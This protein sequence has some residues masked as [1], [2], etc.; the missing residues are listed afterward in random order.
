M[1]RR[2]FFSFHFERDIW[3]ANQVRN[4]NVVVGPDVAGFFD[5]SEYE[6]AKKKGDEAIK[7]MIDRHLEN[8]TVTVVLIG[9]ET[10]SRPWVQYEIQQSIARKNGLLGVQ[11]HHLKDQT[12]ATD[13]PGSTPSVPF[14]V[15]FPVYQWDGDVSR[16]S[17]EIEGAGV[18]CD[19]LRRGY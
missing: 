8:T 13:Y 9:R 4:S 6:D 7:R 12:G 15:Q 5:H 10:A 18:R 16:F 19:I 11:I 1:A 17:R 2:V 14:G 3:R